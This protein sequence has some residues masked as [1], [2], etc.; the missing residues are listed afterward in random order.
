MPRYVVET[1]GVTPVQWHEAIALLARQFPEVG[2]DDDGDV[3]VFVCRAPS[4]THVRRWIGAA[5]LKVA[6]VRLM[7]DSH[8]DVTLTTEGQR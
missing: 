2:V 3:Q 7:D 1:A 4:D 6:S 5:R 8:R